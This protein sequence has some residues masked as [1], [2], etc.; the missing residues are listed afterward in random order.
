[1]KPE[2][3]KSNLRSGI[4]TSKFVCPKMKWIY[5]KTTQKAHRQC[6]CEKTCTSS[7]C[8]RMVYIYP[9]K[10]LRAYPGTI[11]GTEEWDNTYYDMHKTLMS[12]I[13]MLRNSALLSNYFDV[14]YINFSNYYCRFSKI[15]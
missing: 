8:G 11:R 2:G 12:F 6:F 9:E 15:W 1:M 3:S 7:K 13:K 4:P 10:D 5:D 14:F